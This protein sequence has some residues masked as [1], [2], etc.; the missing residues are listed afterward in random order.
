MAATPPTDRE[1]FEH[2][3]VNI[4]GYSPREWENTQLWN[5]LQ[6]AGLADDFRTTISSLT[7]NEI[8]S[9]Q[10]WNTR[11]NAMMPVAM[12]QLKRLHIA[13]SFYHF[14][15]VTHGGAINMLTMTRAL[16]D[17]YR[18]NEYI[19]SDDIVPWHLQLKKKSESSAKS[20]DKWSSR[21]K[22]NKSDFRE[23]KDEAYWNKDKESFLSTIASLGLKHTID[24]GHM[25][26]DLELD[27]SQRLWIYDVMATKFNVP[28]MKTI[29]KKYQDTKDTRLIWDEIVTR[30]DKSRAAETKTI[31]ISNWL[32][33]AR[34]GD[35]TKWRGT[36]TEFVLHFHEQARLFNELVE[37]GEKYSDRQLVTFLNLAIASEPELRSVYETDRNAREAAG[38]LDTLTLEQ[39]VLKLRD[40][41]A[42]LDGVRPTRPRRSVNTHEVIL[43]DGTIYSDDG[44]ETYDIDTPVEQI[45]AYN[46]NQSKPTR[47]PR[48]WMDGD[49]WTKLE[50]TDR[51]A[52][53][54]ISDSGKR[55]IL[56]QGEIHSRSQP[57]Q[58]N[59][60][61][62]AN[63]HETTSSDASKLNV[64]NHEVSS[65]HETTGTATDDLLSMATQKTSNTDPAHITS[66]LAQTK[67]SSSTESS[68]KI[69]AETHEW[70]PE[71]RVRYQVSVHESRPSRPR[72][73]G[74]ST[75]STSRVPD[76]NSTGRALVPSGRRSTYSDNRQI[77][78]RHQTSRAN[79][80]IIV[81]DLIPQINPT[82]R[83]PP[84]APSIS[85]L[86]DQLARVEFDNV[87]P[88]DELLAEHQQAIEFT[89][90][91]SGPTHPQLGIDYD[92]S[93]L[94]PHNESLV[95]HQ[96]PSVPRLDPSRYL[97][98]VRRPTDE[99]PT[100]S[101]ASSARGTTSVPPSGL[102]TNE[103]TISTEP[104]SSEVHQA[105]YG[106][107]TSPQDFTGF[108][109][110]PG[111]PPGYEAS[112]VELGLPPNEMFAG[113]QQEDIDTYS[114]DEGEIDTDDRVH[115]GPID[116][117]QH[118]ELD[119]TL[120]DLPPLQERQE[121]S[122]SS[123]DEM[124]PLTDGPSTT[125]N[126]IPLFPSLSVSCPTP[127]VPPHLAPEVDRIMEQFDR[128]DGV[129]PDDAYM[130]PLLSQQQP[131]ATT[132]PATRGPPHLDLPTPLS[133]RV[134]AKAD[135]TGHVVRPHSGSRLRTQAREFVP[136][137]IQGDT[138]TLSVPT[139]EPD[140][141]GFRQDSHNVR[142]MSKAQ[143]RRQRKQQ[144]K[145]GQATAAQAPSLSSRICNALSPHPTEVPSSSSGDSSGRSSGNE[146]H[147]SQSSGNARTN[148]SQ[149]TSSDPSIHDPDSD[150][151]PTSPT[152]PRSNAATG[153]RQRRN[154]SRQNTKRAPK[155]SDFRKAR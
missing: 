127:T 40:Q 129:L 3:F 71:H 108:A 20:L 113:G 155:S 150:F 82:T 122:S 103:P 142:R 85:E 152:P 44:D 73:S 78:P 84:R 8:L 148:S 120:L 72:P 131:Q 96:P 146:T 119:T 107:R 121:D 33:S 52:W 74:N 83:T 34:L 134:V 1:L 116:Y 149:T 42:I 60:R 111:F 75:G 10:Y 37:P 22:A 50:G 27:E 76:P 110:T 92:T 30:M 64:N 114:E 23:F 66:L 138:P 77:I 39:F 41:C 25:P 117:S 98:T 147:S 140:S 91:P 141:D 105:L 135:G 67:K 12:V 88:L 86:S 43:S 106:T 24:M 115:S 143:R 139:T 16:Y 21:I 57:G 38:N 102:L 31:T 81:R 126:T 130:R 132:P 61:T 46:A 104:T 100:K 95:L 9:L 133:E 36:R 6:I 17:S 15:S 5:A 19:P 4:L 53:A 28:I 45:Y 112:N 70:Q 90:E 80:N 54:K 18:V 48:V 7:S 26:T 154:A 11:A 13:V 56:S 55:L 87:R 125:T 118:G 123:D 93:F 68:G 109:S 58:A 144:K 29:V 65:D 124:P 62:S 2:L 145:K 137:N 136:H 101:H 79:P 89:S 97:D 94:D 153:V 32:T 69:I 128:D 63:L 51:Q 14:M 35:L 99:S 47:P 59:S 151:S 49:T